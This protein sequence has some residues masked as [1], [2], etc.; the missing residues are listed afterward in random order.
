MRG[1]LVA[2]YQ[3]ARILGAEFQSVKHLNG[4][5][6]R[7]MVHNTI[8]SERKEEDLPLEEWIGSLWKLKTGSLLLTPE[9][10]SGPPIGTNTTGQE[11]EAQIVLASRITNERTEKK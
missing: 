5:N 11:A 8:V 1:G 3:S 4:L 10:H 2:L 9:H 7:A 6:V